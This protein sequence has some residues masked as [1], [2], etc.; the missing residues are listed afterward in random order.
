MMTKFRF[1]ASSSLFFVLVFAVGLSNAQ[2]ACAT[3]VRNALADLSANCAQT[4]DGLVCYGYPSAR[5][6]VTSADA[7]PFSTPG[8][9]LAAN[10]VQAIRTS[11]FNEATSL[12]GLSLTRLPLPDSAEPLIVITA[13]DVIVEFEEVASTDV[14][15][16][17]G[18]HFTT[19][20][21][22][23][24]PL[25]PNLLILQGPANETVDLRVNGEVLRLRSTVALGSVDR[26]PATALQDTQ[27]LAVLD[28][29]VL[30]NPTGLGRRIQAGFVTTAPLTDM[31]GNAPDGTNRIAA[32]QLAVLDALTGAPLPAP[33]GEN[34]IRQTTASAYGPPLSIARDS[35]D[36]ADP[37][38]YAFLGELDSVLL[39]AP[40]NVAG[41]DEFVVA[42]APTTAPTEVPTQIPA[43]PTPVPTQVAQANTQ[44]APGISV[45]LSGPRV[46]AVAAQ[47]TQAAPSISVTLSGPRSQPT[48][49]AA[50]IVLGPDLVAPAALVTVET[51]A[52]PNI[53]QNVFM[54]NGPSEVDAIV[55]V[56]RPDQF[57][58][59][60]GTN[61]DGRWVLLRRADG[62]Q[63]WSFAAL[64]T[65]TEP[66]PDA[67]V[68][69]ERFTVEVQP[70]PASSGQ[71]GSILEQVG[72]LGSSSDSAF[73]ATDN[74]SAVA[75]LC[76]VGNLWGDGR[77]NAADGAVREW[78]YQAGWYNAQ[79]VCGNVSDIPDQFELQPSIMVIQGMGTPVMGG[80]TETATPG[81]GTP[82]A[83]P[84]PPTATPTP[85]GEFV[86]TVQNCASQGN[87]FRIDYTL[88][89]VP[90]GS[91]NL[92]VLFESA[93]VV[94]VPITARS[95]TVQNTNRATVVVPIAQPSGTV[96][97]AVNASGNPNCVR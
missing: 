53:S 67:T 17:I 36:V 86:M 89:G 64:L 38:L 78:F 23:S 75:N 15:S 68:A 29:F 55:N 66:L 35:A 88:S 62:I 20:G 43:S 94:V 61:A 41:L 69:D 25:A 34:F 26:N 81:V 1:F 9:T 47:P 85:G 96:G 59:V 31:N 77:C 21:R 28:G 72:G 22:S 71:T 56:L 73:V 46:T 51:F 4:P 48:S 60:L 32:D 76:D 79:L 74:C 3:L 50:T 84:E 14:A 5:A 93:D 13:G 7:G 80:P 8:D 87:D 82:T 95:L 97:R 10:Q 12:W 52:Q 16:G 19:G 54:R 27:V 63:G 6:F 65:F 92:N 39:N 18:L 91:V 57:A 45:T 2:G 30:T 37:A 58:R 42:Q 49:G 24:C 40:L 44:A 33:T 90:V 11:A 83:T 70:A